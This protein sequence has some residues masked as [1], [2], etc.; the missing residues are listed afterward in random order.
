[1]FLRHS[2]FTLKRRKPQTFNISTETQYFY[3]S[4][5]LEFLKNLNC[6]IELTHE[7]DRYR[8][9]ILGLCEMRWKN[10]DEPTTEEGQRF[11]TVEKRIN[12]SMALDFLFT[13]TS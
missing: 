7:M 10:F 3:S 1:M 5:N 6:T 8:W 11:S 13:G 4:L 12:A 9:N 2:Y